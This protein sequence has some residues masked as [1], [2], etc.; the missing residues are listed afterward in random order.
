MPLVLLVIGGLAWLFYARAD[1]LDAQKSAYSKIGGGVIVRF[2]GK[3]EDDLPVT[4]KPLIL[5]HRSQ[6]EVPFKL[7]YRFTNLSDQPVTIR[8]VHQIAPDRAEASFKK[9]ACFCFEKQVL[10]PKETKDMPVVYILSK[11]LPADVDTVYLNYAVFKA[12]GSDA[13]S[14]ASH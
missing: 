9:L 1:L 2:S 12:A 3:V 13:K 5:A 4:I 11:D 7:E 6:R 14:E 8:A 10:A